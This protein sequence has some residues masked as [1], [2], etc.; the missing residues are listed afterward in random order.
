[1]ARSLNEEWDQGSVHEHR[2][3]LILLTSVAEYV[4]DRLEPFGDRLPSVPTILAFKFFYEEAS[5]CSP[6]GSYVPTDLSGSSEASCSSSR[7]GTVACAESSMSSNENKLSNESS[8]STPELVG[9]QELWDHYFTRAEYHAVLSSSLSKRPKKCA[10]SQSRQDIIER[11]TQIKRIEQ[12]G[13]NGNSAFIIIS[14]QFISLLTGLN[15]VTTEVYIVSCS[16]DKV[17]QKDFINSVI[18]PYK[19]KRHRR[20]PVLYYAV[21]PSVEK[22]AVNIYFV[23]KVHIEQKYHYIGSAR[24]I[25][26]SRS[27]VEPDVKEFPVLKR[28]LYG[29]RKVATGGKDGVRPIFGN[30]TVVLINSET[31]SVGGV[32]FEFTEEKWMWDCPQYHCKDARLGKETPTV[33]RCS[34]SSDKENRGV[35]PLPRRAPRSPQKS[36]TQAVSEQKSNRL[37]TSLDCALPPDVLDCVSG[38]L[39]PFTRK[40]FQSVEELEEHLRCS[41]PVFK[42]EK[43]TYTSSVIHFAVSS[44]ISRLQWENPR[45]ERKQSEGLPL[46]AASP[47]RKPRYAPPEELPIKRKNDLP[48][49]QIIP[50]GE[51]SFVHP[52]YSQV[53]GPSSS[54][55]Y[56]SVI[57]DTC[58]WKS[59]LMERNIR[60]Y[61]DDTPQEKEFMLLH[62]RFRSKFRH[63]IVGEKLTLDFYTKFVECCGLEMKKKRIRAHCVARLTRLVQQNKMTPTNMAALTQKLTS[64]QMV[65]LMDQSVIRVPVDVSSNYQ[66]FP[67]F[68]HPETIGEYT[69]TRERRLVPGREDAKYLYEAALAD[70]GAVNLDLN[71]GF[72]TFEDKGGDERLDVLLDWIVSQAPR[73][74]HLKKVLH[75]TDFV[76][77]RGLLTRIA[78]TPFSR[79]DTWEFAAARIKGVIFLCERE[80]EYTKQRFVFCRAVSYTFFKG[81]PSVNTP[82]TSREE[83]GVVVRSE[84][85]TSVGRPLQLVYGAEV[86]AINR[87]DKNSLRGKLIH[88]SAADGRLVELKTQRHAL[89]GVFWKQ[90]SMKWWLQ[91]FLVGIDHIIVGYRN[92]DGIVKKVFLIVVV[93]VVLATGVVGRWLIFERFRLSQDRDVFY[94]TVVLYSMEYL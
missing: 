87:S 65:V 57:E 1:M 51:M 46:G 6:T 45:I 55:I 31:D 14:L 77:W 61:I 36:S 20:S 74:G 17:I 44:V 40:A 41:Y 28:V 33:M 10:R 47:Q 5:S 19:S 58:D 79:K 8:L 59:Q 69:V 76:C 94:L 56:H 91:S 64:Q 35:L 62:N 11:I 49:A 53:P 3:R 37:S 85:G 21:P 71:E 2:M 78:S 26:R 54:K 7:L 66:P 68:W 15:D 88:Y 30:H 86:D 9:V 90:K 42:F 12:C 84:L 60:D 82:V 43:T 23:V 73:G 29:V 93:V 83:F 81:E 89:E 48:K 72:S 38:L 63:S 34:P 52:T 4:I 25:G 50:F 13:N 24:K 16:T 32:S 22:N 67:R 27:D 75:E 80:T 70:G 92:D 39:C 18:V